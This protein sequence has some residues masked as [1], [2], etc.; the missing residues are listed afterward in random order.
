MRAWLDSRARHFVLVTCRDR[1]SG[2]GRWAGGS[3]NSKACAHDLFFD[4]IWRTSL[5]STAKARIVLSIRLR[6]CQQLHS[7]SRTEDALPA[8][9]A[10]SGIKSG[11]RQAVGPKHRLAL[12]S[13]FLLDPASGRLSQN[14]HPRL[15]RPNGPRTDH[16]SLLPCISPLRCI[17]SVNVRHEGA[18][19][20][21][22][23]SNGQRAK[24]LTCRAKSRYRQP[25]RAGGH[26]A[27]VLRESPYQPS[28]LSLTAIRKTNHHRDQHS[29]SH[30]HPSPCTTS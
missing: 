16:T 22:R 23:R 6:A 11:T 25:T 1:N 2:G 24:A 4:Q 19:S 27:P 20:R 30:I 14:G 3:T 7:T 29:H 18:R 10:L 28:V 21:P 17:R 26:E 12:V 15:T 8:S 9:F 13:R 5:P